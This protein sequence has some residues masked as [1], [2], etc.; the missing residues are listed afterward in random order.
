MEGWSE[1]S[2]NL[3]NNTLKKHNNSDQQLFWNAFSSL[4]LSLY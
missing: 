3:Q 1:C 4:M 2:N